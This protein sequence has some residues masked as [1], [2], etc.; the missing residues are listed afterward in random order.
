MQLRVVLGRLSRNDLFLM[1]TNDLF[2]MDVINIK[3]VLPATLLKTLIGDAGLVEDMV[4][5]ITVASPAQAPAWRFHN[6]LTSSSRPSIGCLQSARP[7]RHLPMDGY[8][9]YDVDGHS[10]STTALHRLTE[11]CVTG[12]VCTP[13]LESLS[14]RR[15]L[16]Q[17]NE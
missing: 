13:T 2:L 11:R 12:H 1:H 10:L 9:Q 8:E 17:R 7:H 3:Q 6:F 5:F 4:A 15:E 14:S 16:L